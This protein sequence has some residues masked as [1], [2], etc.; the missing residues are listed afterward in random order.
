MAW[1]QILQSTETTG[2][3]FSPSQPFA[4]R[5]EGSVGTRT[6]QLQSRRKDGTIW[7]IEAAFTDDSKSSVL[8]GLPNTDHRITTDTAG[9][10][11]YWIEA[12]NSAQGR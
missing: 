3:I 1:N 9:I 12:Y 7:N 4:I 5:I 10:T 6:V 8:T 11:A 2:T